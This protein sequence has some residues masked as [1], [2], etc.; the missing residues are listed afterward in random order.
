MY[1]YVDVETLGE[2]AS[3]NIF[4]ATNAKLCHSVFWMKF[5]SLKYPSQAGRQSP[6]FPS[7]EEAPNPGDSHFVRTGM[8]HLR[9]TWPPHK[10]PTAAQPPHWVHLCTLKLLFMGIVYN[11][12]F[13]HIGG[14]GRGNSIL[15]P[16]QL[17]AAASCAIFLFN[18]S[19]GRQEVSATKVRKYLLLLTFNV[20]WV[21]WYHHVWPLLLR[22]GPGKFKLET[23]EKFYRS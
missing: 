8:E 5:R 20:G 18:I 22:R 23:M 2:E 3:H 11:L 10:Q 12:R 1:I 6:S 14:G 15:R 7:C 19:F 16:P 21:V 17:C 13:H 9:F 4:W